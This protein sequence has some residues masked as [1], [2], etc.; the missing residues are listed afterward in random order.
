V[1]LVDVVDWVEISLGCALH[2]GRPYFLL[3]DRLR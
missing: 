1:D 3:L 2:A